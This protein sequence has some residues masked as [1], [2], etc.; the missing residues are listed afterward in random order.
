MLCIAAVMEKAMSALG[1]QR[2]FREVRPMSALPLKADIRG[3][4]KAK[5]NCLPPHLTT[6]LTIF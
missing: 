2:T 5:P 1:Y 6:Q 3:L 4:V